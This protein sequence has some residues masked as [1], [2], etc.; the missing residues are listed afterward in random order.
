MST[1]GDSET[2]VSSGDPVHVAQLL[3]IQK[4]FLAAGKSP[5]IVAL[6]V[7]DGGGSKQCLCL[8]GLRNA[9]ADRQR[10]LQ[11]VA[12]L[13][14]VPAIDPELPERPTESQRPPPALP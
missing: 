14:E 6:K 11:P 9:V 7:R 12:P 10:L 8:Y 13:D 3:E 4:C 2:V 1:R 5:P